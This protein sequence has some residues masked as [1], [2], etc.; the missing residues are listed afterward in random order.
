M[1]LFR[2]FYGD[3]IY[4]ILKQYELSR[5]KKLA[6]KKLKPKQSYGLLKGLKWAIFS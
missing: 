1:V 2:I 6:Q 5:C 3:S 4:D